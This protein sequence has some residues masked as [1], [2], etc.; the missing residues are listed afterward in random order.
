M[1]CYV[2]KGNKKADHFLYLTA[3]IGDE[4]QPEKVPD[5]LL[6]M[7]GDLDF[8][9]DF[10]LQLTR[11]LPNADA[12]QVLAALEDRGFYFQMPKDDM[13]KGEEHYFN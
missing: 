12:K 5:A 10:D 2:Y 7:L 9:I 11:K 3:K 1:Q 13:Y 8:V 6:E 4:K